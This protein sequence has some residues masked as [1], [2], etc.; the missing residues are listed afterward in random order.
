Y[1]TLENQALDCDNFRY[2]CRAIR[3]GEHTA[4]YFA[5]CVGKGNRNDQGKNRNRNSGRPFYKLMID[6]REQGGQDN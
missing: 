2:R 5:A 6:V 4:G 1:T 3:F